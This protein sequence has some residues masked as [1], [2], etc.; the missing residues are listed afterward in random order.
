MTPF[1]KATGGNEIEVVVS[2]SRVV[3]CW[4][5]GH[6]DGYGHGRNIVGGS[7]ASSALANDVTT[8]YILAASGYDR[9]WSCNMMSMII[10]NLGTAAG[11]ATTGD[12][13]IIPT[14]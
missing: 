7:T 4:M 3:K 12:V 8:N 14:T 5:W 2:T 6:P 13:V 11:T 9:T 1:M 10:C